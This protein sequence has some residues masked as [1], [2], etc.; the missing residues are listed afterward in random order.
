MRNEAMERLDL[1]WC[2]RSLCGRF[3]D[4]VVTECI[5]VGW[6]ALCVLNLVRVAGNGASNYVLV[7][8]YL[9]R[10]WRWFPH[11]SPKGPKTYVELSWVYVLNEYFDNCEDIKLTQETMFS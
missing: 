4:P 2:L 5:T 10:D 7:E 8:L 1:P 6:E 11:Q 3:W 9:M